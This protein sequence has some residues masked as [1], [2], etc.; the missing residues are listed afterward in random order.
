M[1]KM[2]NYVHLRAA[3]LDHTTFEWDTTYHS[4]L[5]RADVSLHSDVATTS[6]L[7]VGYAPPSTTSQCA[8]S[9]AFLYPLVPEEK[10]VLDGVADGNVVI[11]SDGPGGYGADLDMLVCTL[12]KLTAEG[13][14]DALASYTLGHTVSTGGDGVIIDGSDEA[15]AWQYAFPFWLELSAREVSSDERLRLRIEVWARG[16]SPT[17]TNTLSLVATANSDDL[18]VRVPMV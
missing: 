4:I 16:G 17:T 2:R 9:L 10:Y 7:T 3:H 8:G 13:V 15:G 11:A 6:Q 5:Y 14:V 18:C 12:E 1:V